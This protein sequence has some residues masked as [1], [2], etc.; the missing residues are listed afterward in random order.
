MRVIKRE[1]G[2][3]EVSEVPYGKVYSWRP[4]GARVEC[5]CGRVLEWSIPGPQRSTC[6]AC[7]CGARFDG[8]FESLDFR[9]ASAEHPWLG[10]YKEWWEKKEANNLK[11]EYYA[12]LEVENS[13]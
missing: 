9:E 12:F 4:G 3:Y 1:P 7:E 10:D 6:A 11:H 2:R 5:D 8:L 13:G